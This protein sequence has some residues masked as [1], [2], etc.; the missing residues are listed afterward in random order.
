MSRILVT[1]GAGFIGSSLVDRLLREGREVVSI[2]NYDPFYDRAAK[3]RNNAE[4]GRHAAFTRIEGD[5]R[6]GALLLRVLREHRI[7][8]VA[9][10]AAKAGVRPSI[11]RPMEYYDVNVMGT[12]ALLEAMRE[13]GVGRIVFGSSSSVY[14]NRSASPFSEDEP[15]DH[16]ISPYAATKKAAELALHAYHHLH[17]LSAIALRFF[18][19]YGPRQRPDLAI[20]KFYERVAAGQPIDVYGDG[21]TGRDYTYIDDI[22]DGVAAAIALAERNDRLF[23]VINLGNNRPVAL[24]ELIAAIERAAGRQA[25]QRAL[26]MQ[27]GDVELT[28]ASITKAQRLL[29]YS[30]KVGLD[31]GLWRFKA[32]HDAQ[33]A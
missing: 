7:G 6:D 23:E 27:P 33:M 2:D 26:P 21:T 3:Q 13:A 22:I 15:V 11:E 24:R 29:G 4:A 32:W 31:E 19:V 8:L 9:H 16:P 5:I 18:T 20:R 28:C 17:G 14:G 25:V 12:M 1:G 30:P 10:L